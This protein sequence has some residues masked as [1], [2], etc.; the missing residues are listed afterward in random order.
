MSNKRKIFAFEEKFGFQEKSLFK[1]FFNKTQLF[2][3][4]NWS[5]SH[6]SWFNQILCHFYF[7]NIKRKNLFFTLNKAIEIYFP[8]WW[9]NHIPTHFFT[10]SRISIR[11]R[12]IFTFQNDDSTNSKKFVINSKDINK[13]PLFKLTIWSDSNESILPIHDS[14]KFCAIFTFAHINSKNL[15]SSSLKLINQNL[16][17]KLMIQSNS[18]A[19]FHSIKDFN[20]I[21]CHFHF[22]KRWLHKFKEIC[23]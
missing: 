18:N 7:R 15:F 17:S 22:S 20:Q 2:K 12:A 8:K 6:N 9:F 21:S 4:T 14:I 19:L 23:Y 1:L 16:L 10:Q 11:S 13:K 5:D 3:L